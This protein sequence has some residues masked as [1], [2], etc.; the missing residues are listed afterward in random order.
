ME[1]P[2]IF[3]KIASAAF[4]TDRTEETGHLAGNFNSL[5]NTVIISPRRWG[6]SSL[7]QKAAEITQ[8]NN[9]IIKFCFIDMFNVRSEEQFYQHFLH[10]IL[11]TTS[12]KTDEILESARNFLSRVVP[13]ISFSPAPDNDF[14]ISLDWKEVKK[15]TD[16]ILDLPEK[17]A[18]VKNIRLMICID[19]FQNISGFEKPVEFQKKLRAHW[20]KHQNVAYCLYGSKRHMLLDVFNSQGMPF[21][22]FGDVIYLEKIS[23]KHWIPFIQERFAGTGKT[24]REEVAKQICFLA[25]NHSFY[26]QQLA[27]LCWLRAKTSCTSEQVTE[28]YENLL[29]QLSFLYQ[30]NTD[31]LSNTQVNF[32]EAVLKGEEKISSK[33]IIMTYK[34]G[35]SSNVNRIKGALIS[36]EIIEIRG[37][38]IEFID[39]MYKNWLKKH[40]FNLF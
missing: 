30:T 7:V 5:I 19:E 27:H 36:K 16:E 28:A 25:D 21:Y 11:K 1:T 33:D 40:Y 29:L 39:P 23:E 18:K 20:Q 12:G 9:P 13:R 26:V 34:L 10:E 31:G 22:N 2:F 17:I 24:I 37:N 15:Q 8:Q 38:K 35:T 32:L 3:G 14:S 6:K 4:F